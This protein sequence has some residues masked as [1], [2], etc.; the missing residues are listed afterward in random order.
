MPAD[1]SSTPAVLAA[2]AVVVGALLASMVT[3]CRPPQARALDKASSSLGRAVAQEDGEAILDHV[4]AGARGTVDLEQML[5]GTA[6]RSW[7]TA[8][9]E[10]EEIHSE[11]IVFV[12][13][14]HPVRVVLTDEGWRFAED[15]TDVYAHDR[16]RSALRALV[17]ATR[18]ERWDVLITLA[19]RRYRLGLSEEDLRRAWTE[20]EHAAALQAARDRLAAHLGDPIVADADEAAL[21]M[22][23]GQVARVEREGDRWVVVEF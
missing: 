23:D 11:A 13:P 17:R 22:G 19:P 15:P 2:R 1:P 16:P 10:P 9:D 4:S 3:G 18:M 5:R 6:R 12:G 14:E 8:L 7:S 20:G 21:D